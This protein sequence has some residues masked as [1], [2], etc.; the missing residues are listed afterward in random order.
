MK[1]CLPVALA[2]ALVPIHFTLAQEYSVDAVHSSIFFRVK[3]MD[4]AYAYGR[5]N[6]FK[7]KFLLDSA[8]PEASTI[9]MEVDVAS[10]D[11][12]NEQRDAHL[13]AADFFDVAKHPTATFKSTKISAGEKGTFLVEGELTIKGRKKPVTFVATKTGEGPAPP[14]MGGGRVQGLE[15]EMTIK[16]SDFEV[17]KVPPP[18]LG[19]EVKLLISLEG[20]KK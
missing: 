20:G 7:G 2:L 17:G 12:A 3:H 8:K 18:I 11:T 10:I 6:K 19:E 9:E 16:R 5:F 14:Q 4:F 13:K 1:L 15:A